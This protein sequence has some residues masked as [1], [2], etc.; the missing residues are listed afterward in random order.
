MK[1]ITNVAIAVGLF[2]VGRLL[3]K[4]P[5]YHPTFPE[6]QYKKWQRIIG[7]VLPLDW[8]DWARI[9]LGVGVVNSVNKAIDKEPPPWLN[10]LQTVTVLTPMM[11]A[12][13]F[14]KATWKHFPLL[15]FGVPLLVQ[16]TSWGQQQMLKKDSIPKWVPNT[17]LPLASTIGGMLGLR[18]FI[19]KSSGQVMGAEMTV[20][21]RCG[22]MHLVCPAEIGEFFGAFLGG[23]QSKSNGSPP[24]SPAVRPMVHTPSLT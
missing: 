21:M 13:V 2:A 23:H 3:H 7:E 12:S 18:A 1:A 4:L 15:A 8:K 20:C 19:A 6:G 16:V 24:P 9:F 11:G 14:S 10:A 17:L 22:G 5:A